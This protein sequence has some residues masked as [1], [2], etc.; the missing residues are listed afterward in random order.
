MKKIFMGLTSYL[1]LLNA[2]A[3]LDHRYIFNSGGTDL[4]AEKNLRLSS[5]S[6]YTEEA[7]FVTEIPAGAIL[8][9]PPRSMQMGMHHGTKKSGFNLPSVLNSSGSLSFWAKANSSAKNSYLLFAVGLGFD[10]AQSDDVLRFGIGKGK[11]KAHA[12][13]KISTG[14]W[15][16]VVATWD[17][18][19][20]KANFYIDG[21]L[22]GS[23][24]V[25]NLDLNES[26]GARVGNYDNMRNNN[27]L[28]ETQFVGNIYD[29]QVYNH[30][31]TVDEVSH[32]HSNP[33]SPAL[34]AE[35][36]VK[37]KARTYPWQSY[38]GALQQNYFIMRDGLNNSQY[39][40]ETTKKGTVAFVG[41]SIT[42]MDWRN[43][44]QVN[45]Q[46]RFP[47]T[48][49]KFILSGVG[50]TGTMYG[51]YRL[52]RDVIQKG[53]V[54]LIFE[55]AAVND[56]AVKRTA[57]Q[58]V[59][60]MEGIVRHAR[61]ANPNVD[62]V[63]MHFACPEKIEDY[64]NGKTPQVIARFDKVAEQYGVPTLDI[65]KE[66][67]ER[68]KRG[69]FTW[70]KDIKGLLPSPF[71]QQLYA[72]SIERLLDEAWSATPTSVKP[73]SMPVKVDVASYDDGQLFPP[74][75]AELKKG[76][77]IMTDY[78][79]K[80][81][82]GKIRTGWNEL[83]QLVGTNPGDSFELKFKGSAVAMMVIAGPKAGIIEH[84]LDGSDWLEQ[85]LF[86][87]HSPNLHL[88][89]IYM[90]RDGLDADKE[91]VLKVRITNKRNELSV[92]NNCRIVYFALNGESRKAKNIA[93]DGIYFE[94]SDGHGPEK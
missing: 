32:L 40:F 19:K 20:E 76:F 38:S 73:H 83:P 70:D 10:I 39:I 94:G 17:H 78:N 89:R 54:D 15:F 51:S 55:E 42:G 88:Q 22:S 63:M 79:A 4:V 36:L 92:G 11:N 81:D 85:D 8:G 80:A 69:E 82:G 93:V 59:R 29:F 62:I 1:L 28:L 75:L 49:F 60:G 57:D 44:V 53:K 9:A 64:K 14:Q 21:T 90:L 6:T 18:S 37:T 47:D 74:Q 52:D 72:D 13:V 58:S 65:T 7:K 3:D 30:P 31:L 41:G 35:D 91:H 87:K 50:S 2:Q 5:S 25:L 67:Y 23:V 66:V 45:L 16:H 56:L 12:Q 84:S 34:N 48:N 33:G 86:T 43:K 24:D 61:R 46:K 27:S 26:T 68:I 77:K 71:G